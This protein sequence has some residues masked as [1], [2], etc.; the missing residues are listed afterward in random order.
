MVQGVLYN[1]NERNRVDLSFASEM[2]GSISPRGNATAG[3]SQGTTMNEWKSS[4]GR[5]TLF[6]AAV[7]SPSLSARELYRQV[8]GEEPDGFQ[9]QAN[10]LMPSI[11]NGSHNGLKAGCFAQ[12]ARIDFNLTPPSSPQEESQEGVSFPLIEDTA[13]LRAELLRI[14]DAVDQNTALSSVVRVALGVQFLALK[15]SSAEA[16]AVLAASI[17]EQY[18][19]K[20]T[21]EEDFIFQINRPYTSRRVEGIKTNFIT[22]WSVDRLQIITLAVQVG[23]PTTSAQTPASGSQTAQF[24]AASVNFD[25]NNVQTPSPLPNDQP[26]SMLREALTAVARMQQAIGLNIEGFQNA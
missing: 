11:A 20:I 6:P 17:P 15:A 10:P 9:R 18:G 1:R 24:I 3:Q 12:P 14:I 19:V 16:N 26:A 2:N 13:L 8:W 5:I 23:G 22:K 4:G 21:D 7:S 25:I